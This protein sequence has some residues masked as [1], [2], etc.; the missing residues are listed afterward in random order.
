MN[1]KSATA[2][3]PTP[4]SRRPAPMSD[5]SGSDVPK[6]DVSSADVSAAAAA[7]KSIVVPPGEYGGG[8]TNALEMGKNSFDVAVCLSACALDIYKNAC[9]FAPALG[10]YFELS[11]RLLA[12]CADLQSNYYGLLKP[13]AEAL[14]A[15]IWG[16]TSC[17]PAEV[18]ERSMDIAI[19]AMNAQV[20]FLQEVTDASA[21][22]DVLQG[23]FEPRQQPSL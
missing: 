5:T 9:C 7:P 14:D 6:K 3:S 12:A 11:S 22:F 8:V 15:S 13:H 2:K 21:S 10:G 17:E 1:R 16:E 23:S 4:E 19:G 20:N 18:L